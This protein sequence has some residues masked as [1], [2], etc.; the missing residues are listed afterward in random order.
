[1]TSEGFASDKN[2]K[3]FINVFLEIF[4]KG[5]NRISMNELTVDINLLPPYHDFQ[6]EGSINEKK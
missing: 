1:V 2:K 5:G 6:V 4:G 3:D